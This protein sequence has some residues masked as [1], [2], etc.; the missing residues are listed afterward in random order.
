MVQKNYK[1]INVAFIVS[2][3]SAWLGEQNYFASLLG[4]INELDDRNFNFYIFTGFDESFFIQKKYKKLKFIRS[5]LLNKNGPFSIC[6][7]ISSFFFKR[8]DPILL[9]LFKKH[10][11]NIL[12]HYK[13]IY[14][15][16]NLTWF[17]DFQHTHLPKFFSKEEI[18]SRDKMYLNY[19]KFSD[20]FIVSSES[21]RKDLIKFK[22][23]KSY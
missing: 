23:K 3:N 7:K 11:I 14:G 21:A 17:P 16:K 1:K 2:S 9:S 18:I 4:A 12:S 8:Y 15:V 5:R 22:K 6:K 19:I 10:S 20:K 13:P